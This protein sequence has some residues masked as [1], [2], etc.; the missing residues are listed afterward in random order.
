MYRLTYPQTLSFSSH[1]GCNKPVDLCLTLS[2]VTSLLHKV[3]IVPSTM[4]LQVY[5]DKLPSTYLPTGPFDKSEKPSVI[6]YL[7][8][9][10]GLSLTLTGCSYTSLSSYSYL[11]FWD[12][13]FLPFLLFSFRSSLFVLR[14]SSFLTNR[15]SYDG[16]VYSITD[17]SP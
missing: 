6:V 7:P 1:Y 3:S 15:S 10:S 12:S 11:R 8:S 4:T 13:Y 5:F 16:S 9:L 2:F 17:F 14:S